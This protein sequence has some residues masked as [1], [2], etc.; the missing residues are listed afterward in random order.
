MDVQILI[1]KNLLSP[2]CP[3]AKSRC[4]SFQLVP[5][6]VGLPWWCLIR[7][8]SGVRYMVPR[9]V[10]GV[11][12]SWPLQKAHRQARRSPCRMQ[13]GKCQKACLTVP[14]SHRVTFMMGFFCARS[15]E[16]DCA[17]IQI[18]V[19]ITPSGSVVLS[20]GYS[21]KPLKASHLVESDKI[22]I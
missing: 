5:S 22:F 12:G 21:S 6:F 2:L 3:E 17:E 11:V 14:C 4:L 7:P 19:I 20:K 10:L 8:C 9:T 16:E 13:W 1:V 15:T 18:Q